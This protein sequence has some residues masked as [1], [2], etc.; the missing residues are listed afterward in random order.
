M[1][2][3]N[4]VLGDRNSQAWLSTS[5]T[6]TQHTRP[7]RRS[8]SPLLRLPRRLI[9][10]LL[11]TMQLL[12]FLP[13]SLLSPLSFLSHR[14]LRVDTLL[15]IFGIRIRNR[16]RR[17]EDCQGRCGRGK[18][19]RVELVLLADGFFVA[20]RWDAGAFEDFAV[21]VLE[22]FGFAGCRMVWQGRC[23]QFVGD[24]LRDRDTWWRRLEVLL[25]SASSRFGAAHFEWKVLSVGC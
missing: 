11:L 5:M 1:P 10:F 25:L 9:S 6:S 15:I 8:L 16:R 23:G 19:R 4:I 21:D 2:D 12:H 3:V 17:S 13:R 20:G 7:H 22:A 14:I 24:L 18:T